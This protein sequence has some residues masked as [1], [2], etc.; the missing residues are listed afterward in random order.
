[1]TFLGHS[2]VENECKALFSVDTFLFV[3]QFCIPATKAYDHNSLGRFEEYIKVEKFALFL[4]KVIAAALLVSLGIVNWSRTVG[5]NS[6]EI[7]LYE[8]K[9][10]Q[11]LWP[12]WT[13]VNHCVHVL[14]LFTT[15]GSRTTEHMWVRSWCCSCWYTESSGN[16]GYVFHLIYQ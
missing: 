14:Q 13:C 9:S 12:W 2:I 5:N 16:W 4:C 1:M 8:N 10:K 6:L 11:Y 7:K 3:L 15:G